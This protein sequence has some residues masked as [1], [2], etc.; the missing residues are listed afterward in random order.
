MLVRLNCPRDWITEGKVI[1]LSNYQ[2]LAISAW[3]Q[4]GDYRTTRYA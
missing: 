2:L 4:D 3:D 1:E